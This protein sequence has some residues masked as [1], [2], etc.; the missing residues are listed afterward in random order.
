M[1]IDLTC[2]AEVV[3]SSM[4]TEQNPAVRLALHNLSDRVIVACRVSVSLVNDRGVALERATADGQALNARPHAAFLLNAPCLPHPGAVRAEAVI[5]KVRFGDQT[6]WTRDPAACVEYTP[7]DLPV[8]PALTH[9]QFVAGETAVG[10]PSLQEGL[11]VC[12]CGRPNPENAEICARCRRQKETIFSR[13][14]RESVEIQFTQRQRQLALA[15]RGTRED[16]A[17][18]QRIR[19]EEYNRRE[20]LRKRRRYLLWSIPLC[21]ALVAAMLLWI[22]P[23]LRKRFPPETDTLRPAETETTE[24]METDEPIILPNTLEGEEKT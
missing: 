19:E 17:R 12:V 5:E 20:S 21:I 18:I 8:S 23:A 13:Y 1:L 2:P 16:M 3:Q 22:E 14:S 15:S 6:G 4:P 24:P 10:F 7:N 11:W 9:L